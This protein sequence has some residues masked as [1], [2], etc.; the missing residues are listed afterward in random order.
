LKADTITSRH[1][2][3]IAD[4][5]AD[6]GV[7]VL[8]EYGDVVFR[9]RSPGDALTSLADA[10][11]LIVR[12]ATRVDQALIDRSPQLKVIGRAGIGVDNVDV[13]AASR[14]GIVVVNAPTSVVTSA[15]EHTVA[16][17]LALCRRVPQAHQSVA[18]GRWERGRF[19]GTELRGKTVGIIG[20]GNIGVE[21]ARR[22]A[23]FDVHLVG[24]DPY[25]TEEMASRLGVQLASL[26]HLLD[27]SDVITIH[28]PLTAST[29]NLIG[30]EELR[31]MKAGARL[32]NCA[33]GG[34]VDEDALVEALA[35]GHL[36]GA[37]LDVFAT[38]PP[39]NR[40]LLASDRVVL[41]P[42]LGASTEE[43]QVAAAV[44][45]AQQVIAV[46]EGSPARYAVNGPA[47]HPE[48]LARLGPYLDLG[49]QLGYLLAQLA[50]APIT[51]IDITY[52]GDIADADTTAVRSAV[53]KG[54]LRTV[55]PDYVNLMNA[56]LLARNRGLQLVEAR[57]T[58]L[59]DSFASSL[60]VA[61]R[62]V[63]GFVRE[64]AGTAI[65]AEPHLVRV[66][67]YRVDV[68][69]TEGYLLFVHHTDQ[70]GVVGKIG[71]LLGNG[72]VNISSMQV[73]RLQPRG[74]AMM[75]LAVDEEID[76]ALLDQLLAET[77]IRAARLVKL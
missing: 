63:G 65:G 24:S 76:S 39:T 14:R 60:S 58:S 26:D 66:D 45:V 27:V 29:R 51:G 40:D 55:S 1:R 17:L 61:L 48:T 50:E 56:L 6:E 23:A 19:V 34:I 71:T 54:L 59:Q 72:D 44:E 22:L 37:A 64:L 68:P 49:E 46:L 52:S 13:E 9:D 31:R 43:A 53:V 28:V 16:L 12:S 57:S 75:V 47:I 30:R 8:Q 18:A 3:L 11:G 36:A 41:T 67:S 42:H 20:L 62:G 35:S 7:R 74:E 70:P 15:A 73:G 69:L 21:V 38:E 77:P 25:L 32:V 2:I 5:I 10:A 4:P 33:R